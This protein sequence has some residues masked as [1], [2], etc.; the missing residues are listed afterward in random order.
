[1][2]EGTRRRGRER[3]SR[4]GRR[5]GHRYVHRRVVADGNGR[6]GADEGLDAVEDVVVRFA[7]DVEIYNR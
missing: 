2:K 5:R 4:S 7:I 1:M 6:V 3:R